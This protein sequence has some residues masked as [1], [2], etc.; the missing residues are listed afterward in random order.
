[1][2]SATLLDTVITDALASMSL[3]TPISVASRALDIPQIISKVL[4]YVYDW[5]RA[6]KGSDVD[7][8]RNAITACTCVNSLWLAQAIRYSW[9][10]C[11]IDMWAKSTLHRSKTSTIQ[12]L[13]DVAPVRQQLYA[14]QIRV[15]LFDIRIPTTRIPKKDGDF[16]F[17]CEFEGHK[18]SKLEHLSFPRLNEVSARSVDQRRACRFPYRIERKSQ[19]PTFCQPDNEEIRYVQGIH[20]GQFVTIP[21]R[22]RG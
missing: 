12:N 11:G 3:Q 6:A 20:D 21:G 18:V 19:R 10:V 4:G 9:Q 2:V 22:C 1:M 8:Y 13:L 17:L 5:R 15:L 16:Y 7:P 14:D